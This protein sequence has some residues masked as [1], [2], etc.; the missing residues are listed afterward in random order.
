[1]ARRR[2]DKAKGFEE[3]H[4]SAFGG[5]PLQFHVAARSAA[6]SARRAAAAAEPGGDLANLGVTDVEQLVALAATEEGRNGLA[7]VLRISQPQL[8]GVVKA[9]KN[10]LPANLAAEL[11]QPLPPMFALGAIEPPATAEAEVAQL[12][13]AVTLPASTNLISNMSP[14]RTQGARGTCVSFTLTA[15]NEYYLRTRG[16][17][18]DL[19]EQHLY[20]AIK[21]LDGSPALC[22][23]WQRVG[24]DVL[25]SRGQCREVIWPYNPNLPCNNNGTMPSDAPADAANY[26]LSLTAVSATSVTAVKSA[27]AAH[28]PVGISI[29]VYNSWF[30][31]AETRRSGR[32]TMPLVNDTQVGGHAL[33]TAGY[34][35]DPSSP[36]GGYFIVR[37]HWSTA[38]GYQCPYGAG[39]GIIPYQYITD[40]CWEAYALASPVGLDELSPAREADQPT[41]TITVRG[42][43]NLVI[44]Q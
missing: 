14:I 16:N 39:Y 31:S 30:Q 38:W 35:D 37:N 12:P 3:G 43:V 1:M 17:R 42:K 26:K 29:P 9:A 15:I 22:G 36:G 32:I 25:S 8:D 24:A 4:L 27:L 11:E 20:D 21:L 23:T 33:C 10:V 6:P 13:Q 34:Q 18:Q 19:S 5:H 28:Q 40:R 41:L 7:T 2:A 44:T